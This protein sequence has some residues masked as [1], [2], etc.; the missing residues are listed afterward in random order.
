MTELPELA[1][2]ILQAL[3]RRAGWF[4][5]AELARAV[6]PDA[7]HTSGHWRRVTRLL[8]EEGLIESSNSLGYRAT[9]KGRTRAARG[10]E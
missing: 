5:G 6:S 2:E 4:T 1:C 7:D 8:R 3:S 9:E 10:P